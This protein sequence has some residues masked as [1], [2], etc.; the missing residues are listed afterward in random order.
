MSLRDSYI[1]GPTGIYGQMDA[2]FAAG[3]DWVD[4]N[5]A[6]IA[7]GLLAN[8][9]M[10]LETFTVNLPVAYQPANLRL[11]GII[12]E[13]FS[14]GVIDQLAAE[15]IYAFQVE[16]VLNTDDALNTSIDLNFTF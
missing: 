13:S 5:S 2:A 16:P 10:G 14:A 3:Q 7:S 12:W 1:T 11:L 9:A 15:N 4:N 8:A 6:A